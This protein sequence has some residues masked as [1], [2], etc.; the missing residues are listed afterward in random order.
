MWDVI[1][2][3]KHDGFRWKLLKAFLKGLN[4]QQTSICLD[5][6]LSE[7]PQPPFL[8]SPN[9]CH[10]DS[11]CV[12]KCINTALL[13]LRHNIKL[14]LA[15]QSANI[16]LIGIFFSTLFWLLTISFAW[17]SIEILKD[18]R[19][20][21]N[22]FTKNPSFGKSLHMFDN[23]GSWTSF[24]IRTSGKSRYSAS[25]MSSSRGIFRG[26][27]LLYIIAIISLSGWLE[28]N[29]IINSIEINFSLSH[30]SD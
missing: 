20:L 23:C 2:L 8:Q 1:S 16:A 15:Y 26:A 4:S 21:Q 17:T 19:F 27:A 30:K 9:L 28:F 24:Q 6:C 14:S 12:S 3:R 5:S 29:F 22:K 25:P 7:R 18:G 10:P 11:W 13:R